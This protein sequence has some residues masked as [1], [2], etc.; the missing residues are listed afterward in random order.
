MEKF[1]LT[2]IKS[3]YGIEIIG[4][5]RR[6]EKLSR[7]CG[8]FRSHV[9][10]HLQCKH[11]KV[12]PKTLQIKF[13]AKCHKSQDIIR[14]AELALLNVRLSSTIAN[15]ARIKS[16]MKK[17]EDELRLDL[18]VDIYDQIIQVDKKRE[19]SELNKA[20]TRQKKKYMNLKENNIP[21]SENR[22]TDEGRIDEEINIEGVDQEILNNYLDQNQ[23]V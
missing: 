11:N 15:L 14:R 10:F 5:I 23:N 12:T 2:N 21:T 7:S 20:S 3:L 17:I 19:E 8:R 1:K 6:H 13:S 18:P 22:K 4:K 9:R 16:N